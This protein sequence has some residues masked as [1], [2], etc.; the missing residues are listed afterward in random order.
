[1]NIQAA[2]ITAALVRLYH[3]WYSRNMSEPGDQKPILSVRFFVTAGGREP[4]REWLS[5]LERKDRRSVGFDI[6]TAQFGWPIGMPLIRKL[7][8]GLWE[9]RSHIANGIARVLFTVEG[10]TM[11]LLH[12]FV[13]KS[14]KSPAADLKTA[15][16]RLA[17]LK[18][19]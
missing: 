6:K 16:R 15:K 10:D 18:K 1:M 11:V 7:E 14:Q 17:E 5:G 9:V 8:P 3:L 2:A 19:R 13:K 12:G 4:V